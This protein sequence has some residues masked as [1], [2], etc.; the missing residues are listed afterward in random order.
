MRLTMG[1]IGALLTPS[2]GALLLI[3]QQAGLASGVG[4]DRPANSSQQR[5]C[6]GPHR[7]RIRASGD[8]LHFSQQGLKRAIDACDPLDSSECDGDRTA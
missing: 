3:D 1:D 6:D 4:L 5:H 7:N 2:E 8:R